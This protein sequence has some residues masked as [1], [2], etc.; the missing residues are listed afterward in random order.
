MIFSFTVR[1]RL[2]VGEAPRVRFLHI[3][4]IGGDTSPARSCHQ[5][6]LVQMIQSATV[7]PER[8]HDTERS[9]DY[10]KPAV[11]DRSVGNA[12]ISVAPS[13]AGQFARESSRST[14][15]GGADQ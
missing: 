7:R 5:Q 10:R 6:Q 11:S 4:D 2:R 13:E 12:A 8:Y 9:R 3:A 15:N 14:T 1:Q